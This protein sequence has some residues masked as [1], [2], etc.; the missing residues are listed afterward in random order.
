MLYRLS[1]VRFVSWH[2]HRRWCAATL[3]W[4]HMVAII[5]IEM[6]TDPLQEFVP[7]ANISLVISAKAHGID[8]GLRYGWHRYLCRRSLQL[9]LQLGNASPQCD[10][11]ICLSRLHG[12]TDQCP[13][14]LRIDLSGLDLMPM[15][16][17]GRGGA[18]VIGRDARELDEI[19]DIGLPGYHPAFTGL[20]AGQRAGDLLGNVLGDVSPQP[21]LDRR[22]IGRQRQPVRDKR[23]A[24][25]EHGIVQRLG[26]LR[27]HHQA[28][29]LRPA[30]SCQLLREVDGQVLA[31]E[32]RPFFRGE[33]VRL[34]DDQVEDTAHLPQQGR[35]EFREEGLQAA[36]LEIGHVD[37]T[38]RQVTTGHQL[39]DRL[40][41]R[42]L[43]LHM[44]VRAAQD[45]E[46]QAWALAVGA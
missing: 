1:C 5:V 19:G 36:R 20:E 29:A 6:P 23:L 40:A 21:F 37:D 13:Q 30:G 16:V 33:F 26:P 8:L 44:A 41:R 35:C 27:H 24:A 12:I 42:L 10:R 3:S 38:Q 32:A 7:P 9:L 25:A 43:D 18:V 14:L 31:A 46:W 11:I 45:L 39:A 4:H 28:N 22:L 17:I 15:I 34:L 2:L